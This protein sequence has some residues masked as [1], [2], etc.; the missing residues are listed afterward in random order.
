MLF[1]SHTLSQDPSSDNENNAFVV[2]NL[3]QE[4]SHSEKII[5]TK[6]KYSADNLFLCQKNRS[7]I[8]C[9]TADKI[10]L[11]LKAINS[12]A[13]LF[14]SIGCILK[15]AHVLFKETMFALHMPHSFEATQVNID[16]SFGVG[17]Y[18]VE[19][20]DKSLGQIDLV[21]DNEPKLADIQASEAHSKNLDNVFDSGATSHY[22]NL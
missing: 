19:Q 22:F 12:F 17:I 10:K 2:V 5:L 6:E 3:N 7:C 9:S 15:E 18:N 20:W 21:L 16:E 4:N 1:D 14:L 8:S 11:N 13:L